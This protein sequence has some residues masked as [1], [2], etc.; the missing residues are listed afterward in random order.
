MFKNLYSK[1]LRSKK[2][3]IEHNKPFN[4]IVNYNLDSEFLKLF[5]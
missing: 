4:R 3:Y 2:N 1:G 5:E